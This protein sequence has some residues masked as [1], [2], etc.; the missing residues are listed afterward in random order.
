MIVALSLRLGNVTGT[1]VEDVIREAVQRRDQTVTWLHPKRP[2]LPG[3]TNPHCTKPC[4][5]RGGTTPMSPSPANWPVRAAIRPV[6]AS[7]DA[8][9]Y[10]LLRFRFDGALADLLD[11]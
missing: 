2:I 9:R 10:V 7:K 3:F 4:V 8:L 11:T 6:S 1:S 5:E